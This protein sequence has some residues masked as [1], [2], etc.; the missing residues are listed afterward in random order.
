MKNSLLRNFLGRISISVL[1]LSA[2]CFLSFGDGVAFASANVT[3]AWDESQDSEVTGYKIY[4]G[5]SSKNYQYS[6]DVQN[7]TSC[8][9]SGLNEGTTY[10]FAATGYT[11]TN[12]ES[13]YSKELSHTIPN[14]PPPPPTA[15]DTDGDD[16]LDEDEIGTY[17]TDPNKID[18]DGDG[19]NDG[20][21]LAFWGE[22]WNND[23]DGDG[24]I[25]LVDPDSDNDGY[26]DGTSPPSSG[27][28]P[29]I[30][31]G[32]VMIDHN[33]TRIDFKKSFI[34]PI[35]I[36]S[37][38]S[39]NDADPAVVRIRT[40]ESTGFEIRVQ[41][42]D[43]LDGIHASETVGFIVMERGTYALEDG[44]LIE[45]GS[46]ETHQVS[47]FSPVSFVQNFQVPPVVITGIASFN[48]VDAVSGRIRKITTEGFEYCMQEQESNQ[49]KHLKETISYISWEPSAGLFKG[50]KYEVG[51]TA[52]A[53]RHNFHSIQFQQ[54]FDTQPIF[55][56]DIQTGDGM[57]TAN[58]RQKD[59]NASIAEIKINEEQSKNEEIRHTTEIVGYISLILI[60]SDPDEPNPESAKIWLEA[61]SGYLS[62]P[63][64]LAE[65][66][67]AS[68]GEYI[69]TRNG[70]GYNADPGS[71][72][73]YAEYTF[74]V[75]FAGDYVIWG[76]VLSAD[77]GSNSF[78][79]FMDNAEYGIWDTQISSAWH[80]E[81]VV[82][83]SFTG[84]VI[85]HLEAGEYTLVIKHREQ[86]SKID[87][88]LITNDM[89]YTPEGTS[90]NNPPQPSQDVDADG[91]G[92][93]DNDEI[94]LYGSDSIKVDTNSDGIND[95]DELSHWSE[96][97]NADAD[98]DGIINLLDPDSDNDNYSDG[99]ERDKGFD[100][101]N[102]D[103]NPG[104]LKIWLEA[105]SGLLN[106]PMEK[107][108]DSGASE[109]EY[110]LIPSGNGYNLDPN[111]AT[112][113]AEYTF[114]VPISGEYIIWGR[115]NSSTTAKD[116]FFV[117]L[118]GNEY[119]IPRFQIHGYG[120]RSLTGIHGIRYP[121]S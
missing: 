56:A 44:T 72:T 112:G 85:T 5:T 76:R 65:D 15:V 63:M 48:E 90:G 89:N 20:E 33:W 74:Q 1:L 119:G 21:E 117:S 16:V 107:A 105:E 84:P 86:L 71:N 49:K 91:D 115:V 97:W 108:A 32:K 61:E 9:I 62:P 2:F 13:N 79:V 50:L 43:Y 18:T 55:L 68:N 45:A 38:L 11:D 78:Y 54:G 109:G 92:L 60:D 46:F 113:Y 51:K 31:I 120:T 69:F 42:W 39:L 59:L 28:A 52:D 34:D 104:S 27:Q 103:S 41:E 88:I 14:T 37:P 98:G 83:R 73:G 26:N 116:S 47:T 3:V 121:T 64:E 67:N 77:G 110:I 36:A 93:Y 12:F 87:R 114:E 102:S 57:D 106:L 80:W 22:N 66:D 96:A 82:S 8:T 35:V 29:T 100:P 4:Y 99:D 40:T 53:V 95:G 118:A 23:S 7:N 30:E 10:Y 25:N 81:Q 111:S 70:N 75:P 101:L 24:L 58:I 6:V 94:N 17:G 19:M